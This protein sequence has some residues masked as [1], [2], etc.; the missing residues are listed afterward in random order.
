MK[1]NKKIL[2]SATLAA[3]A[4]ALSATPAFGSNLLSY[5]DLGTGAQVR[6]HL[7]D[8]NTDQAREAEA[9]AYKFGELKCGEGKC[10]EGKCGEDGKKS[11]DTKEAKKS[12]SKEAAKSESKEAKKSGDKTAEKKATAKSESKTGEA[13]CGEGK[14]G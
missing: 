3:G 9:V 8:L 7:I 4:L 5:N 10:G 6:S 1:T 14:C 11:A 2:K 13:K 12:E